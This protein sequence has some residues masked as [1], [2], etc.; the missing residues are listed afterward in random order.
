M[1][2]IEP[3]V[4]R[5]EAIP[6]PSLRADVLDLLRLI[7]EF[8]AEALAQMLSAA[9]AAPHIAALLAAWQRDP[10]IAALLEVHALALPQP[11]S[12]PPHSPGDFV[13]LASLH[14]RAFT[15]NS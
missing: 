14:S 15:I 6:D 12:P 5:C 11:S 9:A 1:E 8:H 10:Q 2:R 4:A 13:P 7:L 3:L